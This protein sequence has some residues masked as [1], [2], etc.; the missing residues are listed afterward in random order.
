MPPIMIL[1]STV[2]QLCMMP[3]RLGC[4]IVADPVIGQV[5]RLKT[6]DMAI[7]G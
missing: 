4:Y 3:Y 1:N 7:A 6:S 5:I 2:Q